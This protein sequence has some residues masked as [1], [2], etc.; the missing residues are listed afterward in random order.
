LL[1]KSQP[2]N[3]QA[4]IFQLLELPLSDSIWPVV[5]KPKSGFALTFKTGQAIANGL[6]FVF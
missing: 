1:Q 6:T 5:R 3:L 2:G 4:I